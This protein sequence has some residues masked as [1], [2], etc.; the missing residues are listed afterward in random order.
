MSNLTI[1]SNNFGINANENNQPKKWDKNAAQ[2]NLNPVINAKKQM[3]RK[4]AFKLIS[5]AW[6]SDKNARGAIKE[7]EDEKKNKSQTLV[8]LYSK[9]EY[10]ENEK[11]ELKEKFGISDDSQEQKDLEL[12]LKY[13]DNK[14]H[15]SFDRFSDEERERLK[16]L[17]NISLTDYQK[18]VLEKN[19]IQGELRNEA[20]D[21]EGS[22]RALTSAI[23]DSEIERLKSQDMIKA[24]KAADEI[25]EASDKDAVGMMLQD[26]MKHIDEEAEKSREEAEKIREEKEERDERIEAAKEKRQEQEEILEGKTRTDIL[27]L[28]AEIGNKTVNHMSEA[29]KKVQ[30]I[31]KENNMINEDL[32]GIEIDLNF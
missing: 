23:T 16:E 11:S 29:Q 32:K 25:L 27:E 21:M 26:G 1:N 3:A 4:D 9:I 20:R 24:D 6:D 28:T 14:N 5:D 12:L 2:N 31:L 7:M 10:L 19:G 15:V 30:Q 13:Q 18:S 22:L 17:Q 8:E